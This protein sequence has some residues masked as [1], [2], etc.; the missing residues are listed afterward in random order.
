MFLWKFNKFLRE[1]Q[2]DN[3]MVHFLYFTFE[4]LLRWLLEKFILKEILAKA[5]S[6]VKLKRSTQKMSTF[7]N[8][9]VKLKLDLLLS[10]E[11][12]NIK[13]KQGIRKAK[14]FCKEVT[15]LY[16]TKASHF[17]EKPPLKSHIVQYLVYFDPFYIVKNQDKSIRGFGL[18]SERLLSLKRLP[19]S[20][21]VE[22]PNEQCKIF[23]KDDL[24][25]YFEKFKAFDMF[26]QRVDEFLDSFLSDK[27]N[28]LHIVSW[29]VI[30]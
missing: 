17:K 2:V 29:S 7:R 28:C 8:L 22:E 10:Y 1:L 20:E 27:K 19:S 16:V 21:Y 26:Q 11:L 6:G 15:V 3:P 25:S 30:D 18:L 4:G 14:Y 9:L 24:I 5:D 23:I 12:Q 13:R